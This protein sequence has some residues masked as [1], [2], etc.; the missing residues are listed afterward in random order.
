[1]NYLDPFV[2]DLL[3]PLTLVFLYLGFL[4]FLAETLKRFLT[5]D[6]E[7]TRKIVI[8]VAGMSFYWPGG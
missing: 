8:L 2:H 3:Y 7:L 4:V 5:E 6:P 1:M